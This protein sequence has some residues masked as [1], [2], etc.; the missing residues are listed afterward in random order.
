MDIKGFYDNIDHKIMV[1]ML[2]DKIDDK[3]FINL[4]KSLLKA[5]HMEDL[6]TRR[7]IYIHPE[8]DFCGRWRNQD[9]RSS[10]REK[11]IGHA[12]G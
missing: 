5:G 1:K 6:T 11:Q 9:R 12:A 2:E 8:R 3:R 4:I 10:P 7:A